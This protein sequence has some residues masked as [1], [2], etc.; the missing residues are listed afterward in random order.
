MPRNNWRRSVEDEMSNAGHCWY[1]HTQMA[2][3]KPGGDGRLGNSLGHT[4]NFC[5]NLVQYRFRIQWFML[6]TRVKKHKPTTVL[7][8]QRPIMK[9]ASTYFRFNFANFKLFNEF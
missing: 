2:W 5:P 8:I 4:L 9:V 7:V 3:K 6:C 1:K